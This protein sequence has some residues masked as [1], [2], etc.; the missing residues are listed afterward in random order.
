VKMKIRQ[1]KFGLFVAGVML[2]LV[3]GG[4][5]RKPDKGLQ[6]EAAPQ[7]SSP[8]GTENPEARE[9]IPADSESCTIAP[10]ENPVACTMEY[11][12]VCGCDGKTYSNG[13]VARAAGVPHSTAG[14][15]DARDQL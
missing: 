14:A 3:A 13:C 2:L 10:P 8:A 11:D 12:P 6:S 1:P 4:C 5:G 9:S 15:C 7:T